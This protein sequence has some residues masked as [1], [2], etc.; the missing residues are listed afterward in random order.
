M[1]G[2]ES[3]N[4]AGILQNRMLYKSILRLFNN[5][6]VMYVL[7]ATIARNVSNALNFPLQN[8][9]QSQQ[10]TAPLKKRITQQHSNQRQDTETNNINHKQNKNR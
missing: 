5:A 9:K 7:L 6:I 1:N 2:N 4:N 8:G 10:G 3:F